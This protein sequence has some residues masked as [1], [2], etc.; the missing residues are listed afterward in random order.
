LVTG[1]VQNL[2]PVGKTFKL[3]LLTIDFNGAAFT[4][5]NASSLANGIIV[6]ARGT[7]APVANAFTATTVQGWYAIPVSDGIAVQL[8]GVITEFTS[9]GAFK[10]LGRPV[11]AT[12]AQITG[13]S[14]NAP[15]GDGVK[16]EVDGFM[17]GGVLVVKKLRIRNTPGTGGP[18]SFTLIGPIGAYQSPTSFKVKG[19]PVDA[20]GGVV[21]E[22]GTVADLA[23]SRHVTVVGDRVVNGVLIAQHVTFT[24]P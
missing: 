6:R 16:V 15:L 12:N 13:G 2:D 14:P 8:A 21:F 19:Q 24:L 5:M 1:T 22:N 11:D 4:G 9:R 18:A 17:S 3:G 20:S 7:A 10:V 23:N